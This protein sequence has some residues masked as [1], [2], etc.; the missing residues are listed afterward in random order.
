MRRERPDSNFNMKDENT[1]EMNKAIEA[2]AEIK[3]AVV[4]PAD[5]VSP[6]AGAA[7]QGE[8][9]Q[10]RRD[11]SRPGSGRSAEPVKRG[12]GPEE[13][14]GRFDRAKSEYE[15]KPISIRRVTRVVAGGRR[16]SF[17]VA[18]IIGDR[19]G[20]VGLGTGKA[21]DTAL[22]M[23]K[24]LRAAKKELFKVKVTKNGSIAHEVKAKYKSARVMIMPNR[25]RGLVAGSSIRDIL[26]FAGLRNVTTKILSGSKNKLNIARAAIKALKQL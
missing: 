22:S 26:R 20:S 5:R 21:M 19:K 17:S 4:L 16:M 15:Q 10:V 23:T 3:E 24:A 25:E 2:K 6:E 11:E 18:L 8:A 9:R 13:R 12:R 14:R 7:A 1:K